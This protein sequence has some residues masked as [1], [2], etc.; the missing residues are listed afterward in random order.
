MNR[1]TFRHWIAAPLIVLLLGVAVAGCSSQKESASD[2]SKAPTGQV[3]G[4]DTSEINVE[5]SPTDATSK[6]RTQ[7]RVDPAPARTEIISQKPAKSGSVWPLISLLSVLL[8]LG[9]TGLAIY[10]FRWRRRMPDGQVSVVPESILSDVDELVKYNQ[11]Q[12]AT[13]DKQLA[14][15][16]AVIDEVQQSF[17]VFTEVA[18]GKDAQIKRLQEGGDKQVYLQFVRRFIRVTRL[19]ES[20][21][22]EDQAAGKDV[23][24]LQSIFGYLQDALA[25]TGAERVSPEIGADYHGQAHV[26]NNPKTQPTDDPKLDGHI[27]AILH[28][29]YFCRTAEGVVEIEPAIVEIFE[30]SG[31]DQSE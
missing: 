27:T 17:A 5:T 28:P 16:A 10:L 2:A 30:Y 8:A 26:A 21:I 3:T 7:A 6:T 12:I 31:E 22:A 23:S 15:M 4:E 24:A 13:S 11:M 14:E 20:D 1:P 25:D 19:A 18:A 9:S 29:G